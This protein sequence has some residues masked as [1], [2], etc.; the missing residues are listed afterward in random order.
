MNFAF[1][2]FFFL[3]LFKSS[4]TVVF[5]FKIPKIRAASRL[6]EVMFPPFFLA[7]PT[8]CVMGATC[9]SPDAQIASGADHCGALARLAARL[10]SQ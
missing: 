5:F 10:A 7:A 6:H 4:C 8:S 3:S 2:L 1:S 9:P